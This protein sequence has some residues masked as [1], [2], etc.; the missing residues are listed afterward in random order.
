MRTLPLVTVLLVALSGCELTSGPPE[1]VR[2]QLPVQA[3]PGRDVFF[4]LLPDHAS[5]AGVV[6]DYWCGTKT[7]D[8]HIGTDFV[9]GSF[10]EMDEGV[11]VTAAAAGE[12]VEVADGAADRHVRRYPLREDNLVVVRHEDGSVTR[13]RHL[14][15]GSV[16]VREGQRVEAGA[17]LGLVGSSGDSAW[18]HLSFEARTPDDQP[19]DP[20]S[21][22]C[23]AAESF[24]TEQPEYP[25]SFALIDAGLTDAPA[26]RAAI[27]ERPPDRTRLT[28]QQRLTFWVHVANRPAGRFG[29]RL[30]DPA[31]VAADSLVST[32]EQIA[33]EPRLYGGSIHATPTMALG[34]W[35]LE[36]FT[37]DRVFVRLGFDVEES[38]A[39]AARRPAS[40]AT[41]LLSPSVDQESGGLR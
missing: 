14:R 38:Q 15:Q 21:G 23:S 31:G 5:D 29:L 35:S 7:G 1:P 39:S 34:R 33:P 9:I 27:A 40:S 13:Y 26:T 10:R 17:T 28:R 18:P 2:F 37:E 19:F 20:W 4:G 41:R 25:R 6:E 30:I 32:Y 24:W 22:P 36:Y 3:E 8:G 16:T 11:A 12:V